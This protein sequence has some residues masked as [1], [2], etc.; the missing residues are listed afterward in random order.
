MEIVVIGGGLFG[1]AAALE[2]SRRGHRVRLFE[3]TRIPAEKAASHDVSKALRH[4]YGE[5]SALYAPLVREAIDA[6]RELERATGRRLLH[7]VGFLALASNFAPGGFEFESAQWLAR[8][9]IRHE[10]LDAAAISRRFPAFCAT[11]A[12]R[13][14]LDVEA[15][16]LEPDECLLAL[17]EM[18][19]RN[20][21]SIHEEIPIDSIDSPHLV[22][23]DAVIV[24]TGAWVDKTLRQLGPSIRPTLQHEWF[25]APSHPLDVPVYSCDLATRGFYGFPRLRRGHFAGLYKVATHLHGSDAD[26]DDVRNEDP[27]DRSRTEAFVGESL[28]FLIPTAIGHRGC[29]YANTLDGHFLFAKVPGHD[30][31]FAAGG[32]SGHAFKFGPVLGRLAADLV[33]GKPVPAEFGLSRTAGRTV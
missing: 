7:Q 21:V 18:A 3:A 26:P 19:E 13:A 33:E 32:G 10:I 1:L 17:R 29:F 27:V 4:T 30:H 5:K 6:W 14:V 22:G 20:A 28:P 16:Y 2:S 12:D 15:G 9:S 31:V 24:T 23:A 11:G 8:L 25:F